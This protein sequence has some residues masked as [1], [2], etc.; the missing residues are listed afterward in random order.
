MFLEPVV[1]H[2]PEKRLRAVG[3]LAVQGVL[4]GQ[5]PLVTQMARGVA[6]EAA[7]IWPMAKRL[8]RFIWN[9]RFS[10]RDLLKGLCAATAYEH[11]RNQRPL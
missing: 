10:H 5:A 7:T 3:Q 1:Q 2:L 4:G 6:A 11:A 9:K 8:Y